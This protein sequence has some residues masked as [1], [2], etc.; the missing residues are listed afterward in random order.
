MVTD[1]CFYIRKNKAEEPTLLGV[2]VDDTAIAGRLTDVLRA[3]QELMKEFSM[4][5]LGEIKRFLG[6]E[7]KRNREKRSIA[8]YQKAYV[9][10][11]LR[12]YRMDQSN[13]MPTPIGTEYHPHKRLENEEPADKQ[14]YQSLVGSLIY[15]ANT[16][17][18][19]IAAA[20][21]IAGQFMSDPSIYHW[22]AVKRILRYLKGTIKKGLVLGGDDQNMVLEAWVDSDWASDV[23]TRKSRAGFVVKLGSGAVMWGSKKQQVVALSS[24]EAEYMAL[25]IVTR[26]LLWAR[27]FLEEIG[28]YQTKATVVHED[29]RGCIFIANENAINHRT[30]HIDIRHHFIRDAVK[31]GQVVLHPCSTNEMI[32]DSLTKGVSKEKNEYC[33]DGIGLK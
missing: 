22:K 9:E 6:M 30:K 1:P 5:D 16:T 29:N 11:I 32:A 27:Q 7:I 33:C 20:V 28:F 10:G 18:P 19:D 23:E 25:S 12:K 26:E 8:V 14:L 21:G 17:R 24:S 4:T 15:A 31:K 13:P 3:K 2:F